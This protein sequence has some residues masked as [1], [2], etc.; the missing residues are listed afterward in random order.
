MPEAYFSPASVG[1]VRPAEKL[2]PGMLAYMAGQSQPIL[3]VALTDEGRGW[4]ELGGERASTIWVA[5]Y[6]DGTVWTIPEWRLEVDPTS[7]IDAQFAS[8]LKGCAFRHGG[9]AG[10]IGQLHSNRGFA[11]LLPV[12]EDGDSSKLPAG[13]H[14]AYF[15][16]WRIV[17]STPSGDLT[18]VDDEGRAQKQ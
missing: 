12:G 9:R 11:T 18:I 2:R 6:E 3:C 4:F 13:E 17:I 15:S 10:L 14:K 16:R 5:E 8:L 1:E 7:M